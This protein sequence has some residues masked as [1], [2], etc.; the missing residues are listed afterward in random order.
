MPVDDFNSNGELEEVKLPKGKNLL[1]QN[2]EDLQLIHGFN[3]YNGSEFC[4]SYM[5]CS[6]SLINAPFDQDSST[7]VIEIDENRS[8][9]KAAIKLEKKLNA[10]L[11]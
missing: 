5:K 6:S 1:P 11:D 2:P 8:I 4:C 9:P 3:K 10:M 7:N